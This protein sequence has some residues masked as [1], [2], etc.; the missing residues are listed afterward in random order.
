MLRVIKRLINNL[1]YGRGNWVDSRNCRE[2]SYMLHSP[3]QEE[4]RV[5][6]GFKPTQRYWYYQTQCVQ[7]HRYPR[8]KMEP[9]TTEWRN[10][11]QPVCQKCYDT[12]GKLAESGIPFS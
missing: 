12:M 2:I 8:N 1:R 6:M 4:W 5:S 10:L 3:E 7:C 11:D 9:A